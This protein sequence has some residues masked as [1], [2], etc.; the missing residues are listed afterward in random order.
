VESSQ[1]ISKYALT[2]QQNVL[3]GW[4]FEA[5]K[6]SYGWNTIKKYSKWYSI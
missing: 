1:F 4:S 5:Y 3:T 2:V 6:S